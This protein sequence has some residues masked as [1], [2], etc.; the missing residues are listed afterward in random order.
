MAGRKADAEMEYRDS[1]SDFAGGES[2][3]SKE[4]A[5]GQGSRHERCTSGP[6]PGSQDSWTEL[7]K[8]IMLNQQATL[9]FLTM[10]RQCKDEESWPR[11]PGTDVNL[12]QM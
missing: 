3:S 9:N 2:E 7:L 8:S 5:R 4:E 10:Q 12:A 1:M 11:K 6:I